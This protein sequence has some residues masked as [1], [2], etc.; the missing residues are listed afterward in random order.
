MALDRHEPGRDRRRAR[1]SW[2]STASASGS[3]SAPASPSRPLTTMREALPDA[4][5]G[6]ARRPARARRDGPEDVRPRRRRLRRRLLQLDD[7]RVRAERPRARP[8]RR[9]RSRP[10]AAAGARLRAHRGRPRRRGAPRPRR[11][12]ST[13]T[14]TTATATTSSA[15]ASPEGTVGVAAADREAPRR[16]SPRYD[17]ARRRR[18]PR[19]GQRQRR[20]D[21]ALAEAA[22]QA[23]RRQRP[24]RSPRRRRDASAAQVVQSAGSSPRRGSAASRPDERCAAALA[25]L[26][27]LPMDRSSSSDASEHLVR[28]QLG[29]PVAERA[30]RRPEARLE[31]SESSDSSMSGT[32]SASI[33]GVKRW[34]SPVAP[35]SRSRAACRARSASP[36]ALAHHDDDPRLDDRDLLDDAVDALARRPATGSETGHLTQSVP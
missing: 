23:L 25:A 33:V 2:A 5:R 27:Q 34:I 35:R 12:P 31:P 26:R 11:S 20:G 29:V 36:G 15:S 16:S 6:A 32:N 10:R 24:P 4:A 21:D 30:E 8:G 22:P 1:A 7:P 9:Q 18:G 19:P 28:R 3:A 13:A 14:S 17:G